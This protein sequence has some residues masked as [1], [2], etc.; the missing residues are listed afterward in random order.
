[1][2]QKN[3]EKEA[4]PFAQAP[5][6]YVMFRFG[7]LISR[8]FVPNIADIIVRTLQA[9]EYVIAIQSAQQAQIVIHPNLVGIN[10]FELYRVDDLIKRGEESARAALPRIKKLIES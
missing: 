10:W 8:F 2:Q 9:S 5:F 1:M 6:H 3:R 4:I 7:K